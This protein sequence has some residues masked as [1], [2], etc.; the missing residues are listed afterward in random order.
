MW[1]TIEEGNGLDQGDVEMLWEEGDVFEV[2]DVVKASLVNLPGLEVYCIGF[3][4]DCSAVIEKMAAEN[5]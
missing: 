2:V 4:N 1:L 3:F 5:C